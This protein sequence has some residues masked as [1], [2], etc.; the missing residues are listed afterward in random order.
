VENY[1]K[2][3]D[4]RLAARS[5]T[6]GPFLHLSLRLGRPNSGRIMIGSS[7]DD[8]ID[9][10]KTPGAGVPRTMIDREIE[11]CSMVSETTREGT[12]LCAILEK[13][14]GESIR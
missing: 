6:I 1:R 5:S 7:R 2:V 11:S 3:L 13:W 8:T 14:N 9:L 4:T 12:W 10:L